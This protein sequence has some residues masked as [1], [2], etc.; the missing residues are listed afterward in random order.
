MSS[1]KKK[2]EKQYV[3]VVEKAMQRGTRAQDEE[4]IAGEVNGADREMDGAGRTS[5]ASLL[6]LSALSTSL[7]NPIETTTGP[8]PFVFPP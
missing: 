5:A 1:I 2:R 8:L 3:V 4:A 6:E 7:F